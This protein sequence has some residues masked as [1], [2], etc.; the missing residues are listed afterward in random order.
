MSPCLHCGL[1][2]SA[3]AGDA[4]RFCC[5]GCKTAHAIIGRL[6]LDRYYRQR[7]LDPS[8]RPP[9]P[10]ETVVG[11][12]G[13]AAFLGHRDGVATLNFFVEGLHCG[14][15]VWLIESVLAREAGVIWARL[16]MSTG[17]L[18]VRWRDGENDAARI[19]GA[20]ASLGYR[21]VPFDPERLGLATERQDKALLRAMAVAGFAAANIML[22]S[23]GIWAGHRQGMTSETRAL[24][25]WVSALIAIPAIAYSGRPFFASGLAA[26]KARRTNMD[27]P[28]ALAVVITPAVSLFETFSGGRHAYFD[29][30]VTL[31]FFLLIGR[32]LDARARG[33]ARSAAQQLV[34]LGAAAVTVL[35]GDGRAQSLRPE[36]VKTGMTVLVPAGGRIGVDGRVAEGASEMDTSLV[37][38]ESAPVRVRAGDAVF[39]GFLNFSA[40]LR[41]SVTASGD[42]TLLAEIVRLM[43]AAESGRGRYVALAD[44]VARL[45]SPVVHLLAALTFIAWTTLG[46][47]AWQPALLIAVG[48][49]II[50]CP[51]A[52]ALAVPVVQV[53]A[54]GRLM[55]QGILMKS[56]TALERL[57]RVDHVVFD[58]TGTLTE[59]RLELLRE[60]GFN[61]TALAEAAAIAAVSTH[62]LARALARAVPGLVPA[63]GVRDV[64][65]R[66]LGLD[67][68]RGEVRLGSRAWCGVTEGEES[69]PEL[70]LARPGMKPVRFFFHDRVRQDAAEVVQHLN[71]RGYGCELL[72]GDRAATVAEVAAAIGIETWRAAVT[73]ANKVERLA[74][75][76]RQGRRVLMVGDGL[77]DA[78]ALAAA[79][80]SMSPSS[81]ADVSQTAADLVF[82]GRHLAAVTEA[83]AVA[84]ACESLVRQNLAFS[85]LYNAL[86]VPLAVAGLVTP[87]IAAVAMSSSSMVVILNAMRLGRRRGT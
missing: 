70:W 16:S 60:A 41:I 84:K 8:L 77:N 54:S 61:E 23:V 18:V 49:L 24:L 22:L 62:P 59:G 32:Y 46:D 53:V 78:P 74:E 5:A 87:L 79:Y 45:Y 37:T 19:Q 2:V 80:V 26:L 38:G 33:R 27:V 56:A 30:S 75:L 69:G 44:R 86:A 39:A 4:A 25:H 14:A 67:T 64:P 47:L 48:V 29:S 57:A 10:E 12:D 15:C 9:K 76:A 17:R 42:G 28:I 1:P 68:P 43:E 82:Q 20:I 21:A 63:P 66:G 85:L 7:Q 6:G 81:A 50:T 52:L 65:G 31:L 3:T 73:P 36:A 83:L 11:P 71:V 34:S 35:D 55:R 40:P 51:C 58:K 72:S 13:A